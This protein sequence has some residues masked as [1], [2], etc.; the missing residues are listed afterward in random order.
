MNLD[1]NLKKK[2]K[3][4]T[5]FK[6]NVLETESEYSCLVMHANFLSEECTDLICLTFGKPFIY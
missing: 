3:K 1:L 6:Q 5:N 2:Q 4:N